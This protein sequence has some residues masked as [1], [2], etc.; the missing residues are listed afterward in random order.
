[1]FIIR[2]VLRL[3]LLIDTLVAFM[4]RTAVVPAPRLRTEL[5]QSSIA[6]RLAVVAARR[7]T[8]TVAIVRWPS[9]L[10]LTKGLAS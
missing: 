7:S 3:V 5:L 6:A 10:F 1:M 2:A 8:V 9:V 4:V